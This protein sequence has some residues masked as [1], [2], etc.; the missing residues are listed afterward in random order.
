MHWA[1]LLGYVAAACTIC[2][3]S[4]RTMIPLRVMGIAANCM[5]IV[6]GFFGAVY[7]TLVLH[8][9]LLPL[10]STRLYQMIE[11]V[12]KG[13][14]A[15]HGDL[16]IDWLKPFMTK[17][18]YRKGDSVFRQGDAANEMFFTVTGRFRLLESDIELEPGQVVGEL[19]LL[20]P[21]HQRTQSLECVEDG[22]V[23]TITYDQVKQL[24]FQNPKFGFYFLRLTTGRLFENL[25]QLEDQLAHARTKGNRRPR[26]NEQTLS[27][28][29]P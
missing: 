13:R 2:T 23:Q 9:I 14:E 18:G 17:R 22:E 21:N 6:Y 8:L 26:S 10:N 19:G 20:A 29:R 3:Y 24:Y 4:M 5:F 15:A 1:E 25:A 12:R 28:C 27:Q 11:L 7:P 16:S